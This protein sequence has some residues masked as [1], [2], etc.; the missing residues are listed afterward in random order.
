MLDRHHLTDS[1]TKA[2]NTVSMMVRTASVHDSIVA[3]AVPVFG[4]FGYRKTTMDLLA[5]SAGVSR[6]A[7]YQYFSNK[8][9]VFHAVAAYVGEQ[10]HAEAAAASALPGSTADR[11]YDVLAVKLDFAASTVEAGFRR[12]LLQEAAAI[13]PDVVAETESRYAAVV[14]EILAEADE[15][16]LTGAGMTAAEAAALLHDAMLGIVRSPGAADRS[17]LRHLVDLAVRGLAR[18]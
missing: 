9:A 5:Q 8:T 13:A 1:L 12:E 2:T 4:R 6:P 11:L 17:R 18:T 14:A 16:D 15:L 7:V 10:L 3:A